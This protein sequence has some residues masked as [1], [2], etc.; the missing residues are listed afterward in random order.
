MPVP[1]SVGLVEIQAI[2]FEPELQIWQIAV[3]FK[4]IAPVFPGFKDGGAFMYVSAVQLPYFRN[5]IP[6]LFGRAME[7][8]RKAD[9]A[10]R[11]SLDPAVEVPVNS[12]VEFIS[13]VQAF[14][15]EYRIW[16]L[17]NIFTDFE[18]R[19][20]MRILNEFFIIQPEMRNTGFLR[21]ISNL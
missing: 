18:Q 13:A 21:E 15:M 2:V 11:D 10:P 20:D 12:G 14:P 7:S 3:Y 6:F 19:D 1:N 5:E 8:F 16:R 4:P 17:R 9:W